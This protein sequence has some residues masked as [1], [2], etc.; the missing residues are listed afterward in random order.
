MHTPRCD[1]CSK[2]YLF[3]NELQEIIPV[4]QA[5]VLDEKKEWLL[6][7]LTYQTWKVNLNTQFQANLL[8]I[9]NDGAIFIA[10]YKMRIL[11]KSAHEIKT[12]FFG[13]HG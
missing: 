3:F 9:N 10:D 13:K 5:Q 6:Y 4:D 1:E 7:Y 12:E 11:P 8:V 2:F